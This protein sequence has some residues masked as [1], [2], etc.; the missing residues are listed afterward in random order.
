MHD[1]DI[2]YLSS[3]ITNIQ[4]KR[5]KREPILDALLFTYFLILNIV[6]P[7]D[8]TSYIPLKLIFK[9]STTTVLV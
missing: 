4:L 1:Y 9:N 5:M 8:L 7:I 6:S 2:L 3:D